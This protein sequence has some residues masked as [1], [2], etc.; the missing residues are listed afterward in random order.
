MGFNLMPKDENFQGM[1]SRTSKNVVEAAKTFHQLVKNWD[2][3]S[4]LIDKIHEIEHEGDLIRHEL[5]DKLNRT[6]ITPI[7]REDIYA[8][9]GE[10]DDIIDMIQ[11]V[12]DRMKIYRIR[13]IDDGL[14][15]LAEILERSAVL[16]DKAICEMDDKKKVTRVMDYCI[17][18]NQLENEG[19]NMFKKLLADLFDG[20]DASKNPLEVIKWKETYEAV[21]AA[22]DKC[23]NVACTIES[24]VVKGN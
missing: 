11:A 17:E 18:I 24:I 4:P 23:E 7:D 10:L 8:L 6:F 1:F 19:D 20:D 15:K 16:V 22:L 2:A 13:K 21:E 3:G 12:M 5:V 14:V 9:S